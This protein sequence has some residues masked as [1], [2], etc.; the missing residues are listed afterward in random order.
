MP[1]VAD[2]L[3]E[4]AGGWSKYHEGDREQGNA[5]V[6]HPLGCFKVGMHQVPECVERS[7]HDEGGHAEHDST[8]E[9]PFLEQ[10]ERK[11]LRALVHGLFD[12][13]SQRQRHKHEGDH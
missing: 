5:Q 11:P 3:S 4:L 8:G 7:D 9:F 1:A 12:P 6:R 13:Y 2:S 10:I